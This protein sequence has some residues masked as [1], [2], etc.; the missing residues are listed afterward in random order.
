LNF[1]A[2]FCLPPKCGTTSYQRALAS[3]LTKEFLSYNIRR[4]QYK[5]SDRREKWLMNQAKASFNE[6]K[7]ADMIGKRQLTSDEITSPTVYHFMNNFIPSAIVNPQAG[8]KNM[9]S[10]NYMFGSYNMIQILSI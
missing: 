2:L 5:L 7:I 1:S 6:S 4:N 8:I 9:F 10:H 3:Q